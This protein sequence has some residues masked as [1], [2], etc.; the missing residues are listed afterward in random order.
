MSEEVKEPEVEDVERQP[1]DFSGKPDV[2]AAHDTLQTL[3]DKH[4]SIIKEL[5]ISGNKIERKKAIFWDSF[6][7]A[8]PDVNP[9]VPW[10][11]N[12]SNSKHTVLPSDHDPSSKSGGFSRDFLKALASK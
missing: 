11:V 4:N 5:N 2:V 12:H 8:F 9:A 3:I 10:T 6:Y 7:E 1:I